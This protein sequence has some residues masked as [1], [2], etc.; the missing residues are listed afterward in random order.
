MNAAVYDKL[1]EVAK[2]RK[3]IAYGDLA[4]AANL[5]IG[6]DGARKSI[7]FM[8][9]EI[10]EHE[11]AAGRPLLPIVVIREDN[12]MPSSGLFRFARAKKLQKSAD[13]TFFATELKRVYDYWANA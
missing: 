4:T 13:I 5:T 10:A 1:I 3:T 6:D 9:D 7:G 12:N 11:L 2:A 8:L